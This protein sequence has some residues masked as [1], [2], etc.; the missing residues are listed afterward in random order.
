MIPEFILT[1]FENEIK[2]IIKKTNLAI[3]VEY[4]LNVEDLNKFVEDK[5]GLKLEII[6]DEVENFQIKKTK[7]KVIEPEK[8]CIGR[9]KKNGLFCQCKFKFGENE[10]KL[11]GKHSKCV[12]L[13]YG[14][15]NDPVPNEIYKRKKNIY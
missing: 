6:P 5:V 7:N 9:L 8:R 3:S 2:A 13:K 14:T 15:I 11:C 4:N 12:V 10:N 1:L